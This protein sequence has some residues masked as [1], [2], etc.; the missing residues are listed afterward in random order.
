M[1][2]LLESFWLKLVPPARVKENTSALSLR[3][4]ENKY[5]V[6]LKRLSMTKYLLLE[7]ELLLNNAKINL[8]YIL[9]SGMINNSPEQSIRCQTRSKIVSCTLMLN[10]TSK[11]L[12]PMLV[13]THQ[14]YHSSR[15]ASANTLQHITL[16]F[17]M[18]PAN[19]PK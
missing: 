16:I 18:S 12:I 7:M 3:T 1:L 13:M 4:D 10:R 5:N 2:Q 11:I 14:Q 19:F 9:L 17:W 8:V 15:E 6:H